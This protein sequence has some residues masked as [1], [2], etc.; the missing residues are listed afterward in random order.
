MSSYLCDDA[1]GYR[2]VSTDELL[3]LVLFEFVQNRK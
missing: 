3:E 2:L 1:L